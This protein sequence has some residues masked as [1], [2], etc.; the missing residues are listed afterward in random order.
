MRNSFGPP[1]PVSARPSGPP[2]P[3]LPHPTTSVG[4]IPTGRR[5]RVEVMNDTPAFR[6]DRATRAQ[7]RRIATALS[8]IGLALPAS[9]EA[10]QTRCGKPNC[11]C[12]ADPPQLHGPYIVWPRQ[13]NAKTGHPVLT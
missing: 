9:V 2:A 13:A 6:L 3:W 5:G 10:R 12:Q 11:R 1:T 7:Q 8:R 4:L